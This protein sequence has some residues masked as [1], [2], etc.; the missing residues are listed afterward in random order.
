MDQL[1][2]KKLMMNCFLYSGAIDEKI[3]SRMDFF[4]VSRPESG[5]AKG[6]F[7][8][9]QSAVQQIGISALNVENCKMLV[10]IGTDGASVNIATAGLKGLVE[11]KLQWIFWMCFPN[12]W[13]IQTTSLLCLWI[14]LSSPC[15]SC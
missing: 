8:C 4:A 2:W 10:G 11:A 12:S 5:N 14:V 9:L 7:E 15:G 1:T 6:M 3:H 13:Y